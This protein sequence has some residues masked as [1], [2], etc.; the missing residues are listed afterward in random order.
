M[1]NFSHGANAGAFFWF[2]KAR[3]ICSRYVIGRFFRLQFG[4][5]FCALNLGGRFR[6]GLGY[7]RGRVFG[8]VGEQG[9]GGVDT[10]QGG[11]AKRGGFGKAAALL[12]LLEGLAGDAQR[13]GALGGAGIEGGK[14]GKEGGHVS[15]S[16][17]RARRLVVAS[18]SWGRYDK[19]TYLRQRVVD[20]LGVHRP[21]NNRLSF[22]GV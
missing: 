9:G 12:G 15:L 1:N 3:I 10:Q 20:A 14:G 4:R 8:G 17:R 16:I 2:V 7:W 13:G 6:G 11:G 21:K 22:S 18:P 5:L 19:P